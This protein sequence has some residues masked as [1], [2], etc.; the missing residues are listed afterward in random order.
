[1]EGNM[2]IGRDIRNNLPGVWVRL[3]DQTEVQGDW[4]RGGGKVFLY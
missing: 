1:M 3:I 2:Y 4:G